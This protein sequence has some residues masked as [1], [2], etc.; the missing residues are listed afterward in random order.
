MIGAAVLGGLCFA[1]V[2]GLRSLLLPILVLGAIAFAVTELC[3][4]VPAAA[5]WR[6]LLLVVAGLLGITETVLWATTMAGLPTASTLRS[7]SHGLGAWRLTLESTWPARPDPDLLVFVPMLVL[8]VCL[9]GIELLGRTPALVPLLPAIVLAGVSQA[10][11]AL[12]GIAAV[13]VALGYGIALA[14]LVAPERPGRT[15]TRT[16]PRSRGVRVLALIPGAAAVVV[17]AIVGAV[18]VSAADPAGRTPYTL[19]KVQSSSAQQGPQTSPLDDLAGR[20][21]KANAAKPVFRYRADVPVDRWRLIALE[22]FDGV[23]WTIGQPFLRLGSELDPG[24]EVRVP[25]TRRE[26]RIEFADLEGPWLPSQALPAAVQGATEPLVEPVGGTLMTAEPPDRY[27][28][29]WFQPSVDAKFLLRAGV[30][31]EAAGLGDLGAIPNEVAALA[32]RALAG[33]QATFATALAL[34]NYLR[35]NYAVAA[36]DPL[37]TGHSWPRLQRFLIGRE[38][39]TSEQFA[40]AYVAMARANGIPARLVVGFRAPPERDSDGWYTVRNGDA[41]AWPEVAVDG[42]GWWPL[43]PSGRAKTGKPVVPGSAEDV[44]EQA[45][46]EVPPADQIQDP[47]VEPPPAADPPGR[48]WSFGVPVA[49]LFAASSAL[50]LLWLLGVPTAKW[51]RA[52]IRRRRQ[53]TAGVVGA[54]SEVRDRLRAYGVPVAPGMTVRELSDEADELLDQRAAAGLSTVAECV[55]LALWSGAAPDAELT[56]RAWSGVREVKRGLRTRPWTERVQ[57][58]LELRSLV[59]RSSRRAWVSGVGRWRRGVVAAR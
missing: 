18:A 53:G 21:T 54:W 42:V 57:A 17:A 6:P 11:V 10:Y 25:V 38:P 55:D 23:N 28:L 58:A 20:L 48:T 56:A 45:R 50:L 32:E 44:T 43:D 41:L 27:T 9:L 22:D 51:L 49:G 35:T 29:S 8:L 7:L 4:A 59:W 37:P 5:P 33:R 46:A 12:A 31:P 1:P 14:A 3:R 24:A 30:D 19:Q 2:F 13:V 15:T 34:E 39:G 52:T 47:E 16:D 26:A 40:A 36:T